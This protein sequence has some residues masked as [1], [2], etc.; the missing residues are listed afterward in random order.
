MNIEIA[1]GAAKPALS[2]DGTRVPDPLDP[3]PQILLVDDQPARLVTY[4]AILASL[5]VRTVS[6]S[7]GNE[8]LQLLLKRDFAAILLDVNMPD[9]DGFEAARLIRG[10]PR[11]ERT[12]IIFI[13]GFEVSA[14]DQLKGYEVGAIDV[15]DGAMQMNNMAELITIRRY[16]RRW[17]DPRLVVCVLNNEDLSEVTWEQR[18]T[19]GNPRL[20]ATQDLPNVPY[21]KFASML[22]LKGIL[23][24]N[25]NDLQAAWRDALSSDRPVVLE[26]KTDPNVPPL[27]PHITAEQV[28]AFMAAFM[29]G[30]GMLA[31][32]LG[33]S[34][35]QAVQEK[36]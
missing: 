15:G 16:W 28:K 10:H 2:T 25:P 36:T 26:V 27:P 12:P 23:V 33:K 3:R 17:S 30:D 35:K 14:L 11:L 13:T 9:T 6:A 34:V 5:P 8:A 1:L 21:A 18:A 4:E 29:K 24:D 32:V 22:G 20:P 31:R 7:S 19:E